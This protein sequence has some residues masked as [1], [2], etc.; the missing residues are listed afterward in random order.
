MPGDG[1]NKNMAPDREA[2][3]KQVRALVGGGVPGRRD[4]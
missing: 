3:I 4:S 2:Q 1:T